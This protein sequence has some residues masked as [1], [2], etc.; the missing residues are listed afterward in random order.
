MSIAVETVAPILSLEQRKR[1]RNVGFSL[2]LLALISAFFFSGR[3]GDAGFKLVDSFT[4]VLPSQ[5]F[6]R[7]LAVLLGAL[8]AVQ[9]YRGFGKWTN[10]VLA[11]STGA[12]VVGFLAWATSGGSFNL[13]GMLQDTVTRSVPI[14]LGAIAG[15]LC[16][17][18]GVI[19]IAIEGQL[20]GGAFAGS[21]IGS[22]YGPWAGVLGAMAMG[23]ALSALLAVF[24]IRFRVDQVIVGFAINFFSLGLTSFLSQRVLT[25]HPE[26]NIVKPFTPYAIP[27]LSDIPVLGVALFTQ[28]YFVYVSVIAVVLSTWFL[29]RTRW[30]LRT[31]AIGEYPQAAG[32]LGVDVIRLR[33]RNVWIAG[34]IAGLGGAWWP[35][36]TVGRFDQNI[37]SGRGFIALAAVIFGRWH[38]VGALTAALVFGL[39]EAIQLKMSNLDTGIPSEFLLMAPYIVTLIVV[40]GFVGRSRAPKAAGQVYEASK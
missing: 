7:V 27:L 21:V 23:V 28:T 37:T 13:T 15:I 9:L 40:A 17:R 34:A 36:G 39:A 18:S 29:Y 10:V 19:N 26:Y 33:Y 31:R 11:I 8:G 5:P 1:A 32:T 12:F 6:A 14:T 20:L 30:G 3:P 22:L 16:E 38:P 4:L 2:I 24:A 35:I 25:P